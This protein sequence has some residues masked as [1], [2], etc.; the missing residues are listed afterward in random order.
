MSKIIAA[1]IRSKMRIQHVTIRQLAKAMNVTITRV[2]EVR[3]HGNPPPWWHGASNFWVQDWFD[4]I[5]NA[6]ASKEVAK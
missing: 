3:R 5:N 4:G 2:R 6:A 1:R